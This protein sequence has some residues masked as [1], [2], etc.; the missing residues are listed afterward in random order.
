MGGAPLFYLRRKA[1][2]K[3]P[4]QTALILKKKPKD[5]QSLCRRL[6][7]PPLVRFPLSPRAK[8]LF[9]L[10]AKRKIWQIGSSVTFADVV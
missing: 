3:A 4:L 8:P 2:G 6:P 1:R 7:L 10:K 9:S 5:K